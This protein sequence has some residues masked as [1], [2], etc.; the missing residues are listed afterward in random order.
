[1]T[2]NR[3]GF[4]FT[5]T[6]LV[7]LFVSITCCSVLTAYQGCIKIMQQHNQK[8]RALDLIATHDSKTAD[9]DAD[10]K[11]QLETIESDC[12]N[13]IKQQMVMVR[14]KENGKIIVNR[15]RYVI[16]K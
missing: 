4:I 8:E 3:R 7:L 2:A 15:I 6:V 9:E 12:G 13:G 11:L 5:E 16:Q 10:E 1:M 14:Q